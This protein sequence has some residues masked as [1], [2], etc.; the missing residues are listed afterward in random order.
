MVK[1]TKAPVV[2]APA[3]GQL[4]HVLPPSVAAC[5]YVNNGARNVHMVRL[6]GLRHIQL[7]HGDSDKA[8][9][10]NPVTS[11]FDKVF[12]AGQA[13]ID[14]YRAHHVLIPDEKFAI[15]GRPQVSQIRVCRGP[16][17]QVTSPTVLYA[18]TWTG[19]FS[20]ADYCSLPIAEVIIGALLD[21]GATVVF[22]PHP[23]SGRSRASARHI[24]RVARLLAEDTATTGR[25]HLWGS[26]TSDQMSLFDC[27]NLADAMVS[28]VSAVASDW[29]FSEKPLAITDMLGE[30]DGFAAAFPLAEA[31]YVIDRSGGNLGDVLEQLLG[32][33]PLAA[34]RRRLKAYY[35]GDFA[36][37]RYVDA[38]VTEARRCV[39]AGTPAVA[40]RAA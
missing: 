7:L 33:D 4:E 8:S 6:R 25:R 9:S 31:A 29:L 24:A 19:W 30:G 11:M 5:F 3:M 2:V 13:G 27:M 15:V 22:R 18:P 28:D 34:T 35:L 38:F 32:P 1:L 12:V 20:T 26:V 39:E 40:A 23:Y 37:D 21:R 10:Y 14:R 36:E 16:V 17:A